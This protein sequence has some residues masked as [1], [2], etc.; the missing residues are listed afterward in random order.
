MERIIIC[1]LEI[2]GTK[3]ASLLL[4]SVRPL[5]SGLGSGVAIGMEATLKGFTTLNWLVSNLIICRSRLLLV[6][7]P[8]T[9]PI[10]RTPFR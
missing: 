8:N 7:Q 10:I 1:G 3:E 4:K 5:F 6:L 2:G 9:N